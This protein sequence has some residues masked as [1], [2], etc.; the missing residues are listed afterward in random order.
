MKDRTLQ[1]KRRAASNGGLMILH[2]KTGPRRKQRVAAGSASAADLGSEVPNLGV[3]RALFV[4]LVLHVAAIAAIFV[5]N[6]VTDDDPVVM[7]S[8]VKETPKALSAVAAG[9]NLPK[10]AKGEDYYFVATGDTYDRIARSKDVDV[11]ALKELNN[12]VA[13]RAGRILRLPTES[14]V[15]AAAQ[16]PARPAPRMVVEPPLEVAEMPIVVLEPTPVPLPEI[17]RATIIEEEPP[18]QV[19]AVAQEV[20]VVVTPRIAP[21]VREPAVAVI[22]AAAG[23]QDS[24][25][26]YKVKSGDSVWGITRKFKVAQADLLELNGMANPN[27]LRAGMELKIPVSN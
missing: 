9:E 14:A 11:I 12:N 24:G 4:I 18:T 10:V 5:H 19:V 23:A 13:L 25:K 20:A 7:K 8:A 6:K 26:T 27:K 21:P 15:P 2:S 16:V 22:V 1:K 17:A 3:A